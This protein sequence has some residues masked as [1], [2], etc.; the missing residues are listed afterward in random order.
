MP[1]HPLEIVTRAC[2]ALD[3]RP[4]PASVAGMND[5]ATG[6]ARTPSAAGF[7]KR[8]ALLAGLLLFALM[9]GMAPPEGLSPAGWRTA[10][11]AVLMACWWIFEVLPIPVTALLPMLLF[12]LL[13]VADIGAAAAPYAN[14]MIYLFMGGFVIAIAMQEWGLHRRV[15]LNIIRVMGAQPRNILFGFMLAAAFMSLWVSNTAA[16]MLMLPIALSVIGIARR[17]GGSGAAPASQ[18]HFAIALLL[19]IAY[20]ANIGGIGTIIGTPTNALLVGFVRE[21]YGIEISFARW[22]L[23]GLP[24]VVL[25]LPI[26]F[27]TLTRLVFPLR[28]DSLPGG[29]EFIT[30]ELAGL[31]RIGREEKLVALIFALV[32]GAWIARPLLQPLLPGLSDAGI[33]LA[34]VLLLFLTPLDLRGGRF[35][36]TWQAAA[37]LPWGVLILFGG[38][39]SLAAAIQRTGLAQWVG[40]MFTVLDGLPFVLIILVVTAV[41]VFLTELTSNSATAAALL[42]VIGAVAVAVGQDPLLLAVPVAVAASCAFMLPVATPPNAIVYGSGMLSIAQMARAGLWLNLFCTVLITILA[43]WLLPLVM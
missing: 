36:L 25:G 37:R 9:L 22:L 42:P 5:L 10:A 12:P 13:G 35:L 16:T 8:A 34:G 14:P 18:D 20:A 15:A 2:A 1:Q 32:A 29:R 41:V 39:L 3:L 11:V 33:A 26:T 24:I 4:P 43:R 40:G 21:T 23:V 7:G 6:P 38:G 28:G 19:G 17:D 30:R 27:F 31:G